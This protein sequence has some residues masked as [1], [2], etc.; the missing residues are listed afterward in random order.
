MVDDA[1]LIEQGSAGLCLEAAPERQ[2]LDEQRHV[3]GVGVEQVDVAGGAVRGPVR[4]P[5]GES[6][7]QCHRVPAAGELLAG[8]PEG[9][10]VADLVTMR[11]SGD[12][13]P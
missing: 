3:G 12:R 6:F 5:R 4:V 10:L 1:D 2:R 8:R 9:A 11:R 13:G 7:E